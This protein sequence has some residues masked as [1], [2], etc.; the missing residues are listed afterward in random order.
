MPYQKALGVLGDFKIGGQIIHI[1]QYAHELVLL[2]KEE[3]VLQHMIDKIIQIGI[4][5]GMERKVEKT[6]LIRFSRQPSPVKIM[7]DLK[8]LENVESYKYLCSILTNDGRC[9]CEN[10]CRIDMIKTTLKKKRNI[11][12]STLVLELRKKLVECYVWNI[13]SYGAET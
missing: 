6:I 2:A 9:T 13:V 3:N 8:Q 12:T 7:I 10:K 4:C 1:V 5:F 11:F